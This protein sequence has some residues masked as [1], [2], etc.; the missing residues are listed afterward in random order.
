VRGALVSITGT[1]TD[2]TTGKACANFLISIF[3]YDSTGDPAFQTI[4]TTGTAGTYSTSFTDSLGTSQPTGTYSISAN[5][6]SG[7]ATIATA[8]SSYAVTATS[9]STPT[10]TASPSP[11]TNQLTH[12][13]T[14]I[15][16]TQNAT[17]FS[18]G[19][20]I[21]LDGSSSSSGYDAQN[22]QSCPITYCTWLVQ[23]PSGQI[24]GAYSGTTIS[25][26]VNNETWL[27][28]TLIVTANDVNTSP[29]PQ[30]T[31]TSSASI[32]INVEPSQLLTK[33]VVST[34]KV[35]TAPN[36][37]GGLFGPQDL[38]QLYA[39][40]TFNKGVQGNEQV[41]FTVTSPNGTVMSVGTAFT[42]SSGYAYQDF[43]RPNVGTTNFGIW[44]AIAS[45]D[46]NQI[47]ATSTIAFEYNYTVMIVGIKMPATVD[48][49]SSMTI[50]VATQNTNNLTFASTVTIT[51]YD[52]N[53]VLIGS[54]QTVTSETASSSQISATF[55][56]P[57]WAFVGEATV[58]VNVLSSNPLSGGV[59]LCPEKTANFLILS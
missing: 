24:F 44:T 25:I 34:N 31:N 57:S 48:R 3:V 36:P 37:P 16:S 53:D 2:K 4:V 47:V 33:I 23:Y 12:G 10:P 18:T 27:L 50:N 54:Y 49:Q 45:V 19:E 13:P 41:S 38:V 55:T 17:T 28:V 51:I 35:G 46:I 29:D 8:T 20:P 56:I 26:V 32:W 15:I 42:N 9:T 7:G 52:Q 6:A 58:Y 22:A 39:Y 14:A 59:P 5:A 40:V 21:I 11:T 30:Y 43:R 1:L